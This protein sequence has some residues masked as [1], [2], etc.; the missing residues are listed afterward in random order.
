MQL[1][2]PCSICL[3]NKSNADF[4]NRKCQSPPFSQCQGILT[5][6]PYASIYNEH[7]AQR[8]GHHNPNPRLERSNQPS[9]FGYAPTSVGN[10]HFRRSISLLTRKPPPY[11]TPEMLILSPSERSVSTDN[12]T[13]LIM[14][15]LV[16]IASA[17]GYTNYPSPWFS[18]THA[19][20][21]QFN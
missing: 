6:N 19:S 12:N 1:Q 13:T 21:R 16:S 17:L 20:K 7:K 18:L 11:S 5:S 15:L 2:E 3:F 4:A 14:P 8:G 10:L 9:N